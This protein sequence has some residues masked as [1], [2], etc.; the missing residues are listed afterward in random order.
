M[1]STLAVI[2]E[3]L[4]HAWLPSIENHPDHLPSMLLLG[5]IGVLDQNEDILEAVMDDLYSVR[6]NTLD[7]TLKDKVDNILNVVAQLQN[8]DPIP[9]AVAAVFLRPAHPGP[10]QNFA[11]VAANQHAADMAKKVTEHGDFSPEVVSDALAGLGQ[12]SCD[13]RA[14][15]IAPWR[16]SGWK[17]LAAD[18][19]APT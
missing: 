3:A 11:E 7:I 19:A 6:G 14:I 10:W 9:T 4:S 5:S 8:K 15:M 12:I 2:P 17:G 16:A 18:I 13:Q 1:V